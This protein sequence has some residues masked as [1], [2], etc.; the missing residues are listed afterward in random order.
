MNK[1]DEM[2]KSDIK[3]ILPKI[4]LLSFMCVLFHSS[5]VC[6]S[7]YANVH[8]KTICECIPQININMSRVHCGSV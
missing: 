4:N 1:N 2:P 6:I 8:F 5:F 3:F 7:A